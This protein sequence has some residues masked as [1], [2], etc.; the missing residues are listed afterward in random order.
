MLPTKFYNNGSHSCKLVPKNTFT[1]ISG[2]LESPPD[3]DLK[4]LKFNIKAT[5]QLLAML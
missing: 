4:F 1:K 3:N 5:M 2:S